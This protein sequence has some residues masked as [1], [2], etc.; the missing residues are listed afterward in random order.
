M[1]LHFW[2]ILMGIRE[3]LVSLSLDG[4]TSLH[5]L[6][7]RL[8]Y[9]T[10]NEDGMISS[11]YCSCFCNIV[12]AIVRLTTVRMLYRIKSL[13]QISQPVGLPLNLLLRLHLVVSLLKTFLVT[14]FE[15]V[16]RDLWLT[17]L[18]Q[19]GKSILGSAGCHSFLDN[20]CWTMLT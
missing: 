5:C 8:D 19:D 4:E 12:F 10:C 1:A 16:G 2:G 20:D 18:G 11:I 13:A 17:V 7:F 14:S 3:D 9:T 15:W 6:L